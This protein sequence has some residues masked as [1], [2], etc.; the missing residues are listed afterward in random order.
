VFDAFD[1]LMDGVSA[2]GEFLHVERI[3]ANILNDWVGP[4]FEYVDDVRRFDLGL[5]VSLLLL[6]STHRFHLIH[7][8]ST[9]GAME[10]LM[11]A[12]MRIICCNSTNIA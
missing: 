9:L 2:E 10:R 8:S 7:L 1:E 3:L 11:R 6:G 12:E 4:L 5:S